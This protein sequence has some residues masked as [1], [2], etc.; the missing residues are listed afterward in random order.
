MLRQRQQPQRHGQQ[1]QARAQAESAVPVAA[2]GDENHAEDRRRDNHPRQRA[3][4]PVERPPPQDAE[5][6]QRAVPQQALAA[7]EDHARKAD[8]GIGEGGIDHRR[9]R[10]A[11]GFKDAAEP[12]EVVV[13]Q[14]PQRQRNARA[15]RRGGR[16]QSCR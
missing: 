2:A 14:H 15:K 16:R 9:V 3:V 1:E 7:A 11:A 5:D 13:S 6:G 12:R 10:A 8:P 4:A